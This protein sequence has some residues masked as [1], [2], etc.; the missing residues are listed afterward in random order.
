MILWSFS[1]I[2]SFTV[3]ENYGTYLA[4]KSHLRF[5]L[6]NLILGTHTYYFF[7]Y[8]RGHNSSSANGFH[9]LYHLSLSNSKSNEN[10]EIKVTEY[11][12]KHL[13]ALDESI[14]REQEDCEKEFLCYRI[15]AEQQ[16]C[17]MS[18][19][20]MSYYLGIVLVVIPFMVPRFNFS[21][22][23]SDGYLRWFGLFLLFYFSYSLL[24]WILY[25]LSFVKVA[26]IEMS[27]FSD[28][29]VHKEDITATQQLLS[30][31][32]YDW[33]SLKRDADFRVS[34]VGNTQNWVIAT[35]VF[36]ICLLLVQVYGN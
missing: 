18:Y 1:P 25:S 36:M 29:K 9:F 2:L 14:G 8:S 30:N 7:T 4:S 34:Y 32:Y 16:R 11:V 35:T 31:Y 21:L 28:L 27:Q 6:I 13:K 20:K 22:L 12:S 24:N 26:S 3:D 10:I 15:Q 17:D 33:Q 23:P 19:N 5:S